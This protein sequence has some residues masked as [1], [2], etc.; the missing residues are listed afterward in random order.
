MSQ[1]SQEQINAI[2]QQ[3][4]ANVVP[5]IDNT[6]TNINAVPSPPITPQQCPTLMITQTV[7]ERAVMTTA[8]F[9]VLINHLS[10]L[11]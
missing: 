10:L 2:I 3:A 8:H 1:L 5:A 11:F 9:H 7:C 4:I 6:L